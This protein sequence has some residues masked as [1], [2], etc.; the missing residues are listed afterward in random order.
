LGAIARH[1]TLRYQRIDITLTTPDRT[2]TPADLRHIRIPAT[3]DPTAG[4]ILSGR[5]PIWLYSYLV[6]ELHAVA[7][8]GCF[9]PRL[10]AII[11]ASHQP[12]VEVGQ[13][14]P[15]TLREAATM[16]PG[17]APAVMIAGP[18]D[19]GKSVLSH[20]IFHALNQSGIDV[21]L[22]RANWDGEG[23][24]LL[25]VENWSEGDREAFKAANKGQL[26]DRFFTDQA[27]A[28]LFLRKNKDLVLVDVGGRVQPEKQ[29]IL[30]ACSHFLI[31]SSDPQAIDPWVEFCRD[32]GNLD[33]VAILHSVL[34][35][36]LEI[37]RQQPWLELRCGPWLRGN[38]CPI[39]AILLQH[40]QGLPTTQTVKN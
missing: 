15:I 3:I 33:P 40:L 23:N 8:L 12:G 6:H 21:F 27:Q 20:A 30:A 14:L 22:Q 18:P 7:W 2:I 10:G 36:C 4:V 5:A 9:D 17:L 19:S 16:P 1:D 28:I 39:P 29:P 13:T 32:R 38:A 24:Y 11:V 26:T 25:D 34:K 35:P 31:I 37:I